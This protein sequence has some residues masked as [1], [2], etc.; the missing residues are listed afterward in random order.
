MEVLPAAAPLGVPAWS[1]RLVLSPWPREHST[2]SLHS[3]LRAHASLEA[4]GGA[5]GLRCG[6]QG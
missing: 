4:F 6:G 2:L 3:L 1:Y 5:I